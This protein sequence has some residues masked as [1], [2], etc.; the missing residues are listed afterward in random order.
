M[1]TRIVN[2]FDLPTPSETFQFNLPPH[3][4]SLPLDTNN[5]DVLP[6]KTRTSFSNNN[7]GAGHKERRGKIWR[8]TDL[9]PFQPNYAPTGGGPKS[10]VTLKNKSKAQIEAERIEYE[11]KKLNT[12]L[13]NARKDNIYG[14]QFLWNP[15]EYATSTAVSSNVIPAATDALSFLNMFQ[16]TGTINF[17]LQINRVN[18]FACFGSTVGTD[19]TR[20]YGSSYTSAGDR[21]KLINDL[22]RR[23]TLADI[24]FLYKTI[25]GGFIKNAANIETSDIGIIV[26]TIVRVDIGPYAQIGIVN[27]ISV[28]HKMFTQTMIPIVSEVSLGIQILSSFGFGLAPTENQ[29]LSGTPDGI[30]KQP[31]VPTGGGPRTRGR[32]RG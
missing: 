15:T 26:P 10:R 19:F 23:G 2:K 28:A 9:S 17:S 31:I 6:G 32:G 21:I 4:W 29:V 11:Q 24:E 25:N 8:Y 5:L 12:Q 7:W 27:N 1:T 18:D 20:F 13:E 22:K 16:G 3:K 30:L 14:F